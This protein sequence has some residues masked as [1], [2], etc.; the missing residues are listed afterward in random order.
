MD[1]SW[2][3]EVCARDFVPEAPESSGVEAAGDRGGGDGGAEPGR[4]ASWGR[5]DSR[6]CGKDGSDVDERRDSWLFDTSGRE[7]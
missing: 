7:C 3:V 6:S 4:V 1:L 5:N 2:G